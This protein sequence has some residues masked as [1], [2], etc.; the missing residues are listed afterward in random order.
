MKDTITITFDRGYLP[1]RCRKQY[2]QRIKKD[3]DFEIKEVTSDEFVKVIVD[4]ENKDYFVYNNEFYVESYYNTI[5]KIVNREVSQIRT[6]YGK[7]TK[8]YYNP[9]YSEDT[10]TL[11]DTVG[12]YDKLLPMENE[13]LAV[14]DDICKDYVVYEGKIYTKTDSIPCYVLSTDYYSFDV[15][16]ESRVYK[17]DKINNATAFDVKH[18]ELA[19]EAASSGKN[20]LKGVKKL[21]FVNLDAYPVTY[22]NFATGMT[23]K[24]IRQSA[25]QIEENLAF[26]VDAVKSLFDENR[27]R[28]NDIACCGFSYIKINNVSDHFTAL[29]TDGISMLK[30]SIPSDLLSIKV[31]DVKFEFDMN[32]IAL[33]PVITLSDEDTKTFK[34]YYN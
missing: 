30:T 16:V 21:P 22:T 2:R 9:E 10:P 34:K 19:I 5:E 26:I 27:L 20:V 23:G 13:L 18:L 14:I 28:M 12:M 25:D 4:N 32:E 24:Y 7:P 29:Q 6:E 1:P 31:Q 15:C 11:N 33:V 17:I 3:F 8:Y